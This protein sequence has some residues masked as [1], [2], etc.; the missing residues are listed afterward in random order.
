MTSNPYETPRAE[1]EATRGTWPP[2]VK[3]ILGNEA[4]ERFSYYGMKG[5]LAMYIT[6]VLMMTKDQASTII[7]L[8]GF[9]NYFMP[10]IGA[11]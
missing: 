3:F 1:L 5:I 10:V 7:H 6:T 4:A 2:Q 8:F 11:W 9:V